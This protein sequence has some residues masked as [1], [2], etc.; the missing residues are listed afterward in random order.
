M[1]GDL[2][3]SVLNRIEDFQRRP[4]AGRRQANLKHDF[5]RSRI[6]QLDVSAVSFG[7]GADNRQAEAGTALV[8]PGSHEAA[9]ESF[10]HVSRD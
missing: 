5:G 1:D 3:A 2:L 9:K 10:T 4:A 7:D 6:Q 8:G